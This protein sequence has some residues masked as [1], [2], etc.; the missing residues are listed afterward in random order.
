MFSG[1]PP[2]CRNDSYFNQLDTSSLTGNKSD[3]DCLQFLVV[4]RSEESSRETRTE[5]V[6]HQDELDIV[7]MCDRQ[8][9]CS[10]QVDSL[11]FKLAKRYRPASFCGKV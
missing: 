10:V 2:P 8:F 1:I 6:L 9:N 3:G 7:G 5:Y 11:A 4:D